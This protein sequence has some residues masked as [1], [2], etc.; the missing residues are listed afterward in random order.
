M[1]HTITLVPGDGIG[2]E[3]TTATTKVVEYGESI[4]D[5]TC[6][7]LVLDPQQFDVLLLENLYGD[8]VTELGAGLVGG[9]GM[10][11]GANLGEDCAVFEPVHGSAPSIAG[12]NQANPTAMILSVVLLFRYLGES[13]KAQRVHFAVEAVYQMGE[14]LTSDLGG[15]AN[16]TEFT[17]AVVQHLVN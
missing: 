3:V 11:P 12:K 10:V 13:E 1:K 5:N 6:M 9:L 17:E 8:I 4:V 15:K 2:P 14:A 7:Q 16:T